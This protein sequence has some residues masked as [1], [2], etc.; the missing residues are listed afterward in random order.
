MRARRV[1][2]FAALALLC[3]G[4]AGAA[5]AIWLHRRPL[6]VTRGR[7]R[8]TGVSGP[9][10]ILRDRW[11][12]PH[13]FAEHDED[14]Y[15]GLGFAVAQDRLFQLE[16][17]RHLGQGRLSE[18]F[19][20][21]L[22]KAD[23]LFRT[24]DL[25]GIG[26]R[27]LSH[28][29]PE[30]RAAFRAYALG[31]NAAVGSR[32]D[33]LP[34]EFVLLGRRF[35]PATPDDF[36]GVLGYMVWSLQ[37][38]WQ[39]DPLYEE[40][41]G[42]VGA[43][44][45]AELFP[46]TGEDGTA[47]YE[48]PRGPS[49]QAALFDVG[50]RGRDLLA[51]LP[52]FA[53]SNTWVVSPARSA[54]G[55]ALLANDPH[56]GIGLPSTWYLAHLQTPRLDVAGA[57]IP[58]LPFVVIGHNR[59]LAWGLTNLMLDAG[60]FFVEKTRPGT[61]AQVLHRNAWVDVTMRRETIRVRGA[62]PAELNVRSTPHGPIVSDLLEGRTGELS[63]RWSYAVADQTND[64][65]AVYDLERA[66]DW[67]EFRRA[68][69][70]MGGVSQNISYADRDGHIGLQATGA[71]P[72]RAGR[73]DGTRFRT[74]WDGSQEWDGFIPFDENPWVLDPPEGVAVAANNP[75]FARVA[76]FFV[77]SL[78]EPSDRA[79]RIREVLASKPKITLDDVRALQADVVAVSAR[80]WVPLVVQ[81]FD[82][83]PSPDTRLRAALAL[84]RGWDGAMAA[85]SAA[86]ALFAVAHKHLFHEIFDDALSPRLAD[87]FRAEAN[88]STVMI[89]AALRG[90]AS[91]WL[92]RQDTP[93]RDGRSALLRRAFEQAV[94][95]LGRR[96]G[97]EPRTWTWG[98]IHTLTLRHPLGQVR[99]LAPYFDLGP[100]PMPGHALTVFK[101]ESHD[102]FKVY[103]GPS[104]RQVVDLGDP[105]HG[106]IVIPGGQSGIPASPHYGDLFDLWRAGESARVS[107][108]HGEIASSA[109]GRLLLEPAP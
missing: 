68:L 8:V 5:T 49:P 97:G 73:A 81:A 53:A 34:V 79:R 63:F 29:R 25:Q 30:V 60:D 42:R 80:E 12:V 71:I 59:R 41:V 24:L 67:A 91:A 65:E 4:A 70:R 56:L 74:G 11:G 46:F 98:R 84:V 87:A 86:A 14:A 94:D 15:F 83:R 89:D 93:G 45:A 102:D 78:W 27:R 40:L 62:A 21:D 23:R 18:L 85:D 17:L 58:G 33:R 44:R 72:R 6:P 50:P 107:M 51:R 32:R 36:V 69:S 39:F 104:L 77:S 37:L 7:L 101:Q 106:W 13:I 55:H 48:P 103:M 95:E 28:A 108:E 52:G 64:F 105:G 54:S 90:R 88:V 3:L 26:A 19:G 16:L 35:A 99:V 66:R 96:L 57:T 43:A 92:D 75:T 22:I 31:V 61:P 100:Y 2:R 76:P 9:V 38:S 20:G 109:E 82:E 47:V 10:E 1:V